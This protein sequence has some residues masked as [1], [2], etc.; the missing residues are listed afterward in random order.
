MCHVEIFHPTFAADYSRMMK[1]VWISHKYRYWYQDVKIDV[2]RFVGRFPT[3]PQPSFSPTHIRQKS[4]RFAARYFCPVH[5]FAFSHCD[6][7]L[8]SPHH[9]R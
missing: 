1:I 7:D 6:A 5:F 9:E 4:E 3:V 8:T 2:T